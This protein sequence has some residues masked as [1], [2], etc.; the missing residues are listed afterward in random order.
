WR[1]VLIA[2]GGKRYARR[3]VVE[4]ERRRVD[5]PPA[6]RRSAGARRALGAARRQTSSAG[7]RRSGNASRR[8]RGAAAR[9]PPAPPSATAGG[10]GEVCGG[11]GLELWYAWR[12]LPGRP[13][14]RAGHGGWD[15][16]PWLDKAGT[17]GVSWAAASLGPTDA[18]RASIACMPTPH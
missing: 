13:E 8:W 3:R 2:Q 16:G 18:A 9:R 7:T 4:T 17:A 10:A 5:G 12:A 6:S 15:H 11:D 1:H 14:G